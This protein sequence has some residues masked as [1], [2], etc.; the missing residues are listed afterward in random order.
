MTRTLYL[1]VGPPKTG[2]TS[3]QIF[4]RD[5]AA[6]FHRHGLYRP[7]TGT[8]R[9]SHVHEGLVDA[10]RSTTKTAPLLEDLASELQQ[11]GLPD[12]VFVTSELFALHLMKGVCLDNL[13]TFCRKLGYRLHIIAYIRPQAPMFNSLF[14]QCAK[15]W[16]NVI[17]ME[18]FL[19]REIQSGRHNYELLFLPL[20]DDPEVSL[21]IRPLNR[22]T[23]ANGLLPDICSIICPTVQ[24]DDLVEP[25]FSN[26]SP[27]PRTIAAMLKIR[28]RITT[29]LPQLDPVRMSSLTTPLVHIAG[30][31]GW[32]GDKFGGMTQDQ[33]EAVSQHFAASN[34]ILAQRVW[35]TAWKD[36]FTAAENAAPPYN[37][38]T[39]SEATPQ[40]RREFH[41]F[42]EQSIETI[43]EF[44]S[45][46]PIQSNHQE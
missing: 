46:Q 32:N 24:R 18:E 17:S 40:Q 2:S 13:K 36:V 35:S 43:A 26:V 21:T 27:G 28:K 1:H 37:F 3:I 15:N 34:E 45:I 12:H 23:L 25:R 5:N 33:Q 42:I 29:E 16:R 20:Q 7:A 6:T 41:G 39:P 22:A 11:H 31:L 4:V 14:T 9:H 30:S 38:F 19:E 44:A 10:F 8:E